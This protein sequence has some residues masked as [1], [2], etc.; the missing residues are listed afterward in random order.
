ML[1]KKKKLL[2]GNDTELKTRGRS[3]QREMDGKDNI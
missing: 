3:V 2:R 1:G